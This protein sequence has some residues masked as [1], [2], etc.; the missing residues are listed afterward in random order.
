MCVEDPFLQT[1]SH[2][3]YIYFLKNCVGDGQAE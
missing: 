3:Y 1:W 2:M